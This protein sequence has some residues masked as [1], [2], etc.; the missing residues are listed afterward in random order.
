MLSDES[1]RLSDK[2]EAPKEYLSLQE[3]QLAMDT[4]DMAIRKIVLWNMSWSTPHMFLISN[5]FGEVELENR[6]RKLSHLSM[7]YKELG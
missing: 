1:W 4:L 3:F 6:P 2:S 7:K 5:N